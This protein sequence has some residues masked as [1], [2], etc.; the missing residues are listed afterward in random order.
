MSGTPKTDAAVQQWRDGE[1][2]D[3]THE[4]GF[5][6]MVKVSKGLENELAARETAYLADRPNG[7]W[8]DMW[9]SCRVCGG[10]IP[11][12]HMPKCDIYRYERMERAA[13]RMTEAFKAVIPIY[14]EPPQSGSESDDF[15]RGAP[16]TKRQV[17]AM[18]VALAAYCAEK[19]KETT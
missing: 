9:G 2:G 16:I 8:L 19:D 17:K 14:A 13:D 18:Q 6:H 5:R 12:G 11:H 10:E 3:G 4:S 15:A 7:E 1:V